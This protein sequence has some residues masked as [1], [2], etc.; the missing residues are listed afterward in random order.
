MQYF[1]YTRH[2]RTMGSIGEIA[3]PVEACDHAGIGPGEKCFFRAK[4]GV[5]Y[6]HKWDFNH[7]VL[8]DDVYIDLSVF[9]NGMNGTSGEESRELIRLLTRECHRTIQDGIFSLVRR[10]IQAW[11]GLQGIY[12]DPRNEEVVRHCREICEAMDWKPEDPQK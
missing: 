1:N 9:C 4:P 8:P 3:I 11:A 5:V 6:I 12:I 7:R 10:L 2:E